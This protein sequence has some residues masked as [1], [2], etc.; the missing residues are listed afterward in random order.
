MLELP[1]KFD[2]LIVVLG[3]DAAFFPAGAAPPTLARLIIAQM[4]L[5]TPTGIPDLR[6]EVG[7][8]PEPEPAP[9][10]PIAA[11]PPIAPSPPKIGA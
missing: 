11:A 6:A 2:E 9:P 7:L 8:E 1:G 10:P 4:E 3:L 5:R